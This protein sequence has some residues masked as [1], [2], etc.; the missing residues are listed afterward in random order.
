MRQ[1]CLTYFLFLIAGN[2]V[3]QSGSD[4]LLTVLQEHYENFQYQEIIDLASEKLRQDS[5][6]PETR[7]HILH[8]K[9][10]AHYARGEMDRSMAAFNSLLQINP[11]YSLDASKY[12]PKIIEFFNDIKTN[13]LVRPLVEPQTPPE[14]IT[15]IDTLHVP[16]MTPL[17]A[18]KSS[19]LPGWGQW[20]MGEKRKG[21]VLMGAA[22]ISLSGSLYYT[23]QTREHEQNYLN[24]TKL[25]QIEQNYDRYNSSYRK[26]NIFWGTFATLWVL[27]QLDL[28][29]N[30]PKSPLSSSVYHSQ[31]QIRLSIHVLF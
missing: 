1:L 9:A 13:F 24:S 2:L 27:S 11:D 4:P 14:I 20:S 18:L 8:F 15:H 21:S 23:C 12:S 16:V 28:W 5:L 25:P 6:S 31:D 19:L 7:M 17:P 10:L 30:T 26:R 3:A 29:I 22:L